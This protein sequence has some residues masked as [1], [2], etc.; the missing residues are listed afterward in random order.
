MNRPRYECFI[1]HFWF[2]NDGIRQSR[3]VLGALQS[4]AA[5]GECVERRTARHRR[6]QPGVARLLE[7]L[8]VPTRHAVIRDRMRWTRYLVPLPSHPRGHTYRHAN[9]TASF[10][11]YIYHW[12]CVSVGMNAG[13]SGQPPRLPSRIGGILAAM[14][15]SPAC[16]P[17]PDKN[18]TGRRT[19]RFARTDGGDTPS[20]ASIDGYV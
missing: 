11:Q 6:L 3:S 5:A 13:D 16:R 20:L 15:L 9:V 7:R 17:I 10:F 1:V 19:C 4:G 14:G 2:Q 18:G 12:T 8:S